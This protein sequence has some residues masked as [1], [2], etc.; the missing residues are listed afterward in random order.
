MQV[1]N[2]LWRLEASKIKD[3]GNTPKR[4]VECM[5][6]WVPRE[7]AV[8]FTADDDSLYPAARTKFG[9]KLREQTGN[10]FMPWSQ[11]NRRQR[12]TR[13]IDLRKQTAPTH[14]APWWGSHSA[15]RLSR[16][17]SCARMRALSYRTHSQLTHSNT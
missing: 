16:C 2:R 5:S 13:E 7:T 4:I 10:V 17:T 8:F 9:E 15:G 12:Q 6:K 14:G 1:R 11:V 3:E